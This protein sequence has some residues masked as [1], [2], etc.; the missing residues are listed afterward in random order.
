M[1]TSRDA[2]SGSQT[3]DRSESERLIE[4][5]NMTTLYQRSVEV[6]K[7]DDV[8]PSWLDVI[9]D[10]FILGLDDISVQVLR[11]LDGI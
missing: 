1:C 9:L 10:W 5:D 11:R 3:D 4:L 8:K 6:D 2:I 7:S